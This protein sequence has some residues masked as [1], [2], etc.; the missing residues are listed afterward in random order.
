[1]AVLEGRVKGRRGDVSDADLAVVR[2]QADFDLGEIDWARIDSSGPAEAT[3]AAARR[4]L[5]PAEAAAGG[6]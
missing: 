4:K 6:A 3:L 2:M 1:M 5:E